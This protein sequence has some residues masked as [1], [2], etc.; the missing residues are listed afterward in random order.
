MLWKQTSLPGLLVQY[1]W[2]VQSE[3]SG[4]RI[5]MSSLEACLFKSFDHF[6]AYLKTAGTYTWPDGQTNLPRVTAQLLHQLQGPRQNTAYHP[7]PTGMQGCY[8]PLMGL[9]QQQGET[10]G[11][12]YPQQQTRLGGDQTI[13]FPYPGPIDC[14]DPV[15]MNLVQ[16][17]LWW[18]TKVF[19]QAVLVLGHLLGI[20][21]G[22]RG[23][24]Q[25]GI[26]S[27][28]HPTL[29]GTEGMRQLE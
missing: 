23:K 22:R 20:I 16:G 15:G 7:S 2:Q 29:T 17:R 14:P 8:H 26:G 27:L 12:P 11:H 10:V 21:A 6:G 4:Y 1:S 28:R 3:F 18:V 25:A 9:V 19:Q 5:G 13:P 24:V